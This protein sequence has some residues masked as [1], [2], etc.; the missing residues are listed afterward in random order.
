MQDAED[1]DG[2]GDQRRGQSLSEH[3][4]RKIPFGDAA[5][6]TGHD[7]ATAERAGIRPHGVLGPRAP[8][9]IIEGR[10]I[11]DRSSRFAKK[12]E[13]RKEK[14][15]EPRDRILTFWDRMIIR[16]FVVNVTFLAVLLAVHPLA[17]FTALATRG[18][19]F[20]DNVEEEVAEE[21]RPTLFA[22]AEKLEWLYELSRENP[23]EEYQD[24][25]PLPTPT[26]DEFGDA[27]I[28]ED[29]T[30]AKDGDGSKDEQDPKDDGTDE[31]QTDDGTDEIEIVGLDTDPPDDPS[32]DTRETGEAPAWPMK[33]VLHPAVKEMPKSIETDYKAVAKYI[34]GKEDD[35][36]LRVKALNDWAADRIAYDVES[37][38]AG[39]YPPQDPETVFKTRKAV[40]AGYARM[41]E[42]MAKET[43]DEIVYIVG[44]SRDL[45]GGVAGGGHAWNAAKIEGKWY[46]IDTTWNAG[47]VEGDTFKKEYRTNYLFT[48]PDVFSMD[49]LPDDQA[50]QLRA[51]PITRGEFVRQPMLRSEFY[52]QG[53]ELVNPQRSQFEWGLAPVKVNLEN[54]KARKILATMEPHGG[55]SSDQVRCDIRGRSKVE[56]SCPVVGP[57]KYDLKM[58]AGNPGQ[59]WYPFVGKFEVVTK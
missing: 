37:L 14:G 40:C 13:R 41:M 45:T 51:D 7:S 18:D 42:A 3:S 36:F 4:D 35:P 31:T 38:A 6:H 39:R 50:W 5:Q 29:A 28:D 58:F 47:F 55:G 23:Y 11:D 10:L 30:D 9:E 33:A 25:E 53:L 24:D 54:P 19:W 59:Q 26:S 22:G 27:E 56:I 17:G 32:A 52:V 1:A 15:K 16:T 21:I 12:Q 57:G 2:R 44:D 20:L 43:G 46:L 34:A 49:H 48:P 8:V